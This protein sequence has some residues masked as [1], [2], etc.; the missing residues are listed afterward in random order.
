MLSFFRLIRSYLLK[1]RQE[2]G[3]ET[4]REREMKELSKIMQNRIQHLQNPPDCEK[5]RK[6]VCS[7]NKGMYQP[8]QQTIMQITIT[9]EEIKYFVLT[10]DNILGCGFG[11]QIHHVA[12]CMVVA[13]A[14]SRT[15]VLES[16]GWRYNRQGWDKVFMPVSDSCTS[17]SGS[18]RADWG[19]K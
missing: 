11:C 2:D 8:E 13:Y 7:I 3:Y 15:L 17:A 6:V 18:S 10:Y 12:Y 14:T 16:K 4:Y 9:D 5:A 1:L 19:C